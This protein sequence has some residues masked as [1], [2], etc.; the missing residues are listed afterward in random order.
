MKKSLSLLLSSLLLLGLLYFTAQTTQAQQQ[1]TDEFA[2]STLNSQWTF[3]DTDG[4][5]SYS[6]SAN[7][8]S[9]TLTTNSPPGRDLNLTVV[10]APRVMA[11]TS[12]NN[13]FTVETKVSATTTKGDEGAGIVVWYNSNQFLK[14]VRMS[15]GTSPVTQQ[16][17]FAVNGESFKASTLSSSINPTY[18]KLV[19]SSHSYSAY[20][21]SDGS[22]WTFVYTLTFS[23]T[24]S[25]N[26]GLYALN[27]NHNDTFTASFDYFRFTQTVT[28]TP[29]PT[30]SPTPTAS[31]TPTPTPTPSGGLVGHWDFDGGYGNAVDDDSGKGNDGSISGTTS[32][33]TG[34]S[35]TALHFNGSSSYVWVPD[36][37]SLDINGSQGLTLMAWIKPDNPQGQGT[38]NIIDK[39][40]NYQLVFDN[41]NPD[42]RGVV[43]SSDGTWYQSG[44][45]YIPSG[46]WHQYVGVYD[47]PYLYVYL[48]GY[49]TAYRNVGNLEL[50]TNFNNLVF[51]SNM[52]TNGQFYGSIDEVS[53]YSKALNSSEILDNYETLSAQPT[54]TPSPTPTSTPTPYVPEP[55]IRPTQQPTI[56]PTPIGDWISANSTWIGLFSLIFVLTLVG[57][58]AS[59]S[60]KK[61]NGAKTAGAATTQTTQPQTG[62]G[63][64]QPVTPPTLPNTAGTL[65]LLSGDEQIVERL[66]KTW[67][68]VK[69]GARFEWAESIF[70]Y[71]ALRTAM[72]TNKRLVVLNGNMIDIEV[73]LNFIR[74]TEKASLSGKNFLKL[75]LI[76]GDAIS[77]VFVSMG[78][79]MSYGSDYMFGKAK[80]VVNQWLQSIKNLTS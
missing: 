72:L 9:L 56:E 20:Y 22:T 45:T 34:I 63:A 41:P 3:I 14:L 44:Q 40:T 25:A 10:N 5:S 53:I 69:L 12:L 43:F 7:P 71:D 65:F 21:S 47:Q 31:P 59:F 58:L 11:S 74:N 38:A 76:N 32:W 55:T 50:D 66:D 64:T 16:V 52:T 68:V 67:Q 4:N 18:L 24:G 70:R 15:T 26:I 8:G 29:T 19:K 17:Y 78:M 1:L 80:S 77:L 60:G 23:S 54:P 6:L 57:V 51:G 46:V 30:V 33:V 61:K 48:D 37:S 27:I 42:L 73:P 79:K 75:H 13:D 36:S 28:S 62:Q 49:Q 39:Y 35:G 2:S